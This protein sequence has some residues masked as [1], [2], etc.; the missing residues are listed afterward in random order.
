M[1][2]HFKL[3]YNNL[4]IAVVSFGILTFW[5]HEYNPAT[6]LYESLP[7]TI[8]FA[9]WVVIFPMLV[10]WLKW[11]FFDFRELHTPESEQWLLSLNLWR[12]MR[13]L[14]VKATKQILLNVGSQLLLMYS[15][16]MAYKYL[17]SME[18]PIYATIPLLT[19]GVY[20]C[21]RTLWYCMLVAINF[22]F[23]V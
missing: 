1:L 8:F 22:V 11:K 17:V 2:N 12:Y 20:M 16:S 14:N 19:L 4:I 18:V 7:V 15:I 13:S 5:L 10:K 23:D 9:F 6:Q 21:F 3:L